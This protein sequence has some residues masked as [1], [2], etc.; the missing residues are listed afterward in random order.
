MNVRY[1]PLTENGCSG[2]DTLGDVSWIAQSTQEHSDMVTITETDAVV[3]E[4]QYTNKTFCIAL[5]IIGSSFRV[6]DPSRYAMFG[7]TFDI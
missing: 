7:S 3:S 6:H 5:M 1:V 2:Q 4:T